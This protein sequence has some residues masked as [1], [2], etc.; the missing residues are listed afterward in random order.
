MNNNTIDIVGD[1]HNYSINIKS[2]E[3]FLHNYFGSGD[4][5]NPGVEYKMSNIFIKNLRLLELKS[6]EHIIVHMHSVGGSWADGM[7]MYDAIKMCD[8]YVTIISYGQSESMSSIILQAAD[9]RILSK[10]SYFMAHYGSSAMYGDYLS[11]QNWAQYEQQI[12]NSMLDIYSTKCVSGKFFQEKYTKPDGLKVKNFLS[13]K[14]KD[15][16]WYMNA[17]EAVYYGFADK[18]AENWSNLTN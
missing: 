10:H 13:K 16:D 3:I 17:E 14:L 15:G 2:R 8:S 18:V 1:I 5:D 4:A 9:C 6:I 11:A 12:C 7:A